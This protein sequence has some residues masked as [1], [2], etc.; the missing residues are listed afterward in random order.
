MNIK[1][2]NNSLSQNHNHQTKDSNVGVVIIGR[3]EGKRLIGCLESLSELI[4][5]VVYVD[6]ASTDNSLTEAKKRGVHVVSLDMTL[7]FTAARARNTGF[8]TISSLY[9]QIEFVQFVDGDCVVNHEWIQTATNFLI[10]NPHVA[11][12]CGRRR[13][14]NPQSSIY[15]HMCDLEWN[16]PL[17]EAKACGGD[18]LIRTNVFKSVGGFRNSLIAGEEPELCIRI[19]QAGYSVW[20]IDAEMTLH[21]AAMTKFGQWWK[22][23]MRAGYAFAEGAYLHGNAPE[24]HWVAESKRAWVWGLILPIVIILMLIIKPIIGLILLLVYPL[25]LLRLTVKSKQKSFDAFIQAI[26]SIL[27]KFAEAVGQIKFLLNRYFG[28][29]SKIIEYK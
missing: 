8:D 9:P 10:N 13:E 3:N 18:A 26:F 11:V 1:N 23:T 6:S 20:R 27:G 24:Y 12:A 16:T 4:P 29:Q 7:P 5:H 21:D 19:R 2:V 17:G 15:N 25:Q 28:Q 14:S 22:R